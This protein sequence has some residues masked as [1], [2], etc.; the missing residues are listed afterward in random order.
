MFT[1]GAGVITIDS[2]DIVDM[3][4]IF[5][6]NPPEFNLRADTS[7]GPPEEYYWTRN[8][9]RVS[10]DDAFDIFLI[11]VTTLVGNQPRPDALGN[12][13]YNNTLI[14]RGNLPGEY[15]YTVGNRATSPMVTSSFNIEGMLAVYI[16]QW[17]RKIFLDGG[18]G[19]APIFLRI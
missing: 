16:L 11:V 18:G 13:R 6:G 17:C 19:G 5:L 14:V 2:V 10:D 9:Q 7:G 15:E 1:V 12:S 8:G 4:S 3:D